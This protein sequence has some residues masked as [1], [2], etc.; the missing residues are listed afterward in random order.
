MNHL[1]NNNFSPYQL[2]CHLDNLWVLHPDN[3]L[4]DH[5]TFHKLLFIWLSSKQWFV[6]MYNV[7]RWTV[8]HSVCIPTTSFHINWHGIQTN[9]WQYL[10]VCRW[11]LLNCLNSKNILS[12]RLT[13]RQFSVGPFGISTIC[14]SNYSEFRQVYQIVWHSDNFLLNFLPLFFEKTVLLL[15]RLHCDNFFS[16]ELVLHFIPIFVESSSILAR[17]C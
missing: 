15:I 4:S 12:N 14:L 7:L 17:L 16:Y 9:F 10:F 13:F 6:Q 11:L 5:F 1:R 2:T 3:F 8:C